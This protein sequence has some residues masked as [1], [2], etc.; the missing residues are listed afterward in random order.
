MNVTVRQLRAFVFVSQLKS[1]TKAAERLHLTQ[2]ALSLLIRQ[3]ED[4][5]QVQLIERSTRKVELTA[6]GLELMSGAERLLDD[7]DT[8]LANVA[9]LGAKQRG[10]VV[11]AAPYILATTFLVEVI[12]E[13]KTRF[14]TISVHLKDSL[15]EQVLMQV[16]SGGADLGIGSFREW[17]PGLQWKPL[18][19]EPLVAVFPRD[20]PI[21][22]LAQLNWG[23][24]AGLP[25][26]SLNRDSIFRDLAEDG[27]SQ[28]G[29]SLSP[30]YEVAYAGTALALVRVG[31]G[32]AILPQCVGVLI[33][34]SIAVRPLE[35]P[36]IMRS[37]AVIT[38][39]GRSLSPA[40]EAF[41]DILRKSVKVPARLAAIG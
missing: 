32:I 9:E 22:E 17:E 21:G 33:D 35:N 12:A 36:Q 37:V 20:H 7:L 13:F 14:P 29:F 25:V 24:L 30:A 3:L 40:A 28:A 31:L 19:Q 16:R 10:K 26:I 39:D 8:A 11:I 23:D 38:R 15:P 41:V 18:F 5:L 2:S 27:F 34:S 4:N 1:F 6:A